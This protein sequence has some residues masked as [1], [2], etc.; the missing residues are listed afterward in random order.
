MMVEGAQVIKSARKYKKF[1]KKK[2]QFEIGLIILLLP[3]RYKKFQKLTENNL[4]VKRPG[5]GIPAHEFYSVVGKK[6]NKRILKN[7][8]IIKKFTKINKIS[9]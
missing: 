9:K 8:Q 5:G 1:I 4:T 2:L 7:S 6:V 3:N